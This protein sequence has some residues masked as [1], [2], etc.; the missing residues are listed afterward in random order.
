MKLVCKEAIDLH[1]FSSLSKLKT[2]IYT[3]P[4]IVKKDIK[5]SLW[6]ALTNQIN[7]LYKKQS[8]VSLERMLT[9]L[10]M[11]V[12]AITSMILSLV[13]VHNRLTSFLVFVVK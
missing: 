3:T 8:T 5:S 2:T 1:C 13:S 11:L 10:R 12:I 6:M 7:F 9:F 4:A